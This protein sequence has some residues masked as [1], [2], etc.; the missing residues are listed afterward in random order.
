M[1]TDLRLLEKAEMKVLEI[2]GSW[3]APG[4]DACVKSELK[5]LKSAR[6]LKN[7]KGKK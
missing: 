5:R 2:R 4:F 3:D 6:R 1:T 7:K